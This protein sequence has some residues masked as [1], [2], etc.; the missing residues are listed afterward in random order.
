MM[1]SLDPKISVSASTQ[2]DSDVLETN[3]HIDHNA[4]IFGQTVI[5]ISNISKIWAGY[6]P[7]P[8]FPFMQVCIL[9]GGGVI[10]VTKY[11]SLSVIGLIL[12]LV[13]VYLI[14][15]YISYKLIYT[16]NIE[17]N[18]GTVH[19]FFSEEKQFINKMFQFLNAILVNDSRN[20]NIIM[21][22]KNSNFT[23]LDHSSVIDSIIQSKTN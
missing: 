23:V 20:E 3:L 18:S 21:D 7:K 17:L 6:L 11:T 16:L 13:G 9:L 5:Q 22:F 12:I 14:F 10:A 15:K 8:S 1:S 4:L 19:R 2:S